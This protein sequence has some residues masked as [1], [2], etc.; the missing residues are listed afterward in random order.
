MLILVLML[1]PFLFLFLFSPRKLSPSRVRE[2]IVTR[3]TVASSPP[4]LSNHRKRHVKDTQ[5]FHYTRIHSPSF[6]RCSCTLPLPLSLGLA[7][8]SPL[9]GIFAARIPR[10]RE[11]LG[12][13]LSLTA[14]P[15]R[16]LDPEDYSINTRTYPRRAN[17]T[18]FHH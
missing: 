7:A 14:S 1:L 13:S 5:F 11:R 17:T 18:R 10:F 4:R 2:K 3:L 12:Q 8:S 6:L 15:I 16:N 9:S